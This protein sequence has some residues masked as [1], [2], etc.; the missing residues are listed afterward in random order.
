MINVLI[1]AVILLVVALCIRSLVND[2]KAGRSSCGGNC[3]S[4][5][6]CCHGCQASMQKGKSFPHAGQVKKAK[7]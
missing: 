1:I 3:S 2:R 4:C 7:L 6:A 5:G